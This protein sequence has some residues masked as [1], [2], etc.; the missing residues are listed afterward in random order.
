MARGRKRR[1]RKGDEVVLSLL[2]NPEMKRRLGEIADSFDGGVVFTGDVAETILIAFFKA[3]PLQKDKEAA[4]RLIIMREK[5][6]L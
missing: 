6:E 5:G 2:V 4:R 1:K 3:N